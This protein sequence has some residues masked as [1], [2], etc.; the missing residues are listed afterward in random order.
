MV[1]IRWRWRRRRLGGLTGDIRRRLLK[2]WRR[3][4]LGILR[5]L[6]HSV[7]WR[8]GLGRG[9]IDRRIP[10]DVHRGR[11]LLEELCREG[12]RSA[13]ARGQWQR[14]GRRRWTSGIC[15]GCR[16]RSRK[17]PRG[18]GE[19]CKEPRDR[20][21]PDER[22]GRRGS[23]AGTGWWAKPSRRGVS[24]VVRRKTRH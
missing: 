20:G 23:E 14:H 15:A 2:A 13:W 17:D 12:S 21:I 9:G 16:L 10:R 6:C 3:R 5:Q 1:E 22:G 4:S 8:D 18:R 19:R 7:H 11:G 24:A